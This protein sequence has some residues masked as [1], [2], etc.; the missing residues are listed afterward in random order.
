MSVC[1][2]GAGLGRLAYEVAKLGFVCQGNEWS[3][4]MLLASHVLLNKSEGD[5]TWGRGQAGS[6]LSLHSLSF[7]LFLSPT[8]M[9]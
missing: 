5:L 8:P 6:S 9:D 4:H 2:P 1:V 3:V 7:P